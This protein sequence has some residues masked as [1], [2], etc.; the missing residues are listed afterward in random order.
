M[1]IIKNSNKLS[2][3]YRVNA[4]DAFKIVL[5][6]RLFC[7]LDEAKVNSI[8]TDH[9]LKSSTVRTLDIYQIQQLM[10]ESYRVLY[11]HMEIINAVRVLSHPVLIE[12]AYMPFESELDGKRIYA[13]CLDYAMG[14]QDVSCTEAP[15]E[16]D[17][18]DASRR[19]IDL[20]MQHEDRIVSQHA[21]I[22]AQRSI[23]M[24]LFKTLNAADPSARISMTSADILELM[25][26]NEDT[27]DTPF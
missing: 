19:W 27:T 9:S 1:T 17:N 8:E 20:A 11:N 24:D 3:H 18:C 16:L 10:S 12:P 25:Q 23:I 6:D 13:L 7:A 14:G 22:Q 15:D 4:A 2:E 21:T 5:L 26:G